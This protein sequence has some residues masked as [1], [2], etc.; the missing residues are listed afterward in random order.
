MDNPIFREL[1]DEEEYFSLKSNENIF[2][3]LRATS[4]YVREAEKLETKICRLP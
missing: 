2:L 4:G 3:D 1:P